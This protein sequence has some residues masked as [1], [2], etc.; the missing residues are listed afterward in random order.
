MNKLLTIN[1]LT[2]TSY[3]KLYTNNKQMTIT[4]SFIDDLILCFRDVNKFNECLRFLVSIA[5]SS[6]YNKLLIVYI[7]SG[8]YD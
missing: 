3:N 1:K 5:G 7:N 8:V 2:W 6:I 4:T